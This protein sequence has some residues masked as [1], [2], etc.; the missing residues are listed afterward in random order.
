LLSLLPVLAQAKTEIPVQSLS[1][2]PAVYILWTSSPSSIE[3]ANDQKS[4]EASLD[5]YGF[6][7]QRLVAPW[8]DPLFES[9]N[10][11]LW[12]LPEAAAQNLSAHQTK[13]LISL[14]Q[15]GSI[16]ITDGQSAMVDALGIKLGDS[17][18]VEQ[19]TSCVTTTGLPLQWP[20]RP[21]VRPI[22][23]P[24][25]TVYYESLPDHLPLA[26]GGP[27]G[28][29]KY[30]YFAPL[31]DPLTEEGWDR[32]PGLA[33]ILFQWDIQPPVR[34]SRAEA[35]FDP[36]YREGIAPEQLAMEWKNDGIRAVYAAAWN[37]DDEEPYDYDRLIRAA[38]QQG[39]LVYAW[40][41]WPYVSKTFWN[42]HPE[43]REK[44]AVLTDA[45]L[46]FRY[47]M[48]FQNPD[49]WEQ[50]MSDAH[51]FLS[52]HDWDG[53]NMPEFTVTGLWP[54]VFAGPAHPELLTPFNT[55][56][57][58]EFQ[59][60]YGY[61]PLELVRW[62]TPHFWQ[63]NP[64]AVRQFYAYR[65]ALNLSLIKRIL[66]QFQ[67]WN[68][69]EERHWEIE[70][71]ELDGL[72][73]STIYD[74]LGIDMNALIAMIQ[75]LHGTLQVEDSG[76]QWLKSPSR[77]TP[78]I[79]QYQK[80]MSDDHLLVDVNVV[81]FDPTVPPKRPTRQ[82]TGAEFLALWHAAQG[83]LSRA[84]FYS[85][86]TI[87]ST[88]WWL[89][90]YAMGSKTRWQWTPPNVLQVTTPDTVRVRLSTTS[91]AYHVDG[92]PW[93]AGDGE[94][95]IL[96]AGSHVIAIDPA[97]ADNLETGPIRLLSL[98]DELLSLKA[99]P[100]NLEIRYRAPSRCEFIFSRPP[101]AVLIDGVYRKLPTLPTE[102]GFAI[103]APEGTHLLSVKLL[104][105]KS[106]S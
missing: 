81:L 60:R 41:Q 19:A 28:K 32:F 24:Q 22:L 18:Q 11:A 55:Q 47:L 9:L 14:V 27:K 104:P 90:P 46:D 44:T 6:H 42:A 51:H 30:L 91:W 15:E 69:A 78:L 75:P 67:Q 5:Q 12:I 87:P 52:R 97:T 61:D 106:A 3:S 86:S 37:D 13:R 57:R 102:E 2:Y 35:Y 80:K 50:V 88:D 85:E 26:V 10:P 101:G 36:G 63:K 76:A 1:I 105:A 100:Q 95:V 43:W 71:T 25:A 33:Q 65:R 38:H 40:F 56:A 74:Y 53:I 62:Q 82:A 21:G 98:S 31:Y 48:N 68:L 49:C 23:K 64:V 92:Q 66:T 7:P 29:G 8:A 72:R 96:P 39:I 20:D 34:A 59:M 93:Y 17:H 83:P 70:L 16:L 84:A 79:A 4:L 45:R 89:L 103:F 73:E 94:N 99:L 77:Y 58:K 54:E